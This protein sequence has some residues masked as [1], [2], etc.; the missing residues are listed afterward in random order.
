MNFHSIRFK[1]T[2]P[3]IIGL[4]LIIFFMQFYLLPNYV[5]DSKQQFITDTHKLIEASINGIALNLLER[6]LSPIY[7]NLEHLEEYYNGNWRNLLL[8]DPNKQRIYPVFMESQDVNLDFIHLVHPIIIEG[9]NL[10]K[11][12]VDVNWGQKKSQIINNFKQ[13]RMLIII[14]LVLIV[15]IS[16]VNEYH[17]IFLPLNNLLSATKDI[18]K[19]N[20]DIKLPKASKDEMGTLIK[21]FS[22]MLVELDFKNTALEHHAIVCEFDQNRKIINMNDSFKKISGYPKK[23]LDTMVIDDLIHVDHHA[24][25]KEKIVPALIKGEIWRGVIKCTNAQGLNYW[26]SSTIVPFATETHARKRFICIQTDITNQKKSEKKLLHLANHDTLTGLPTRILLMEHLSQAIE[27]AKRDKQCVAVA[28]VDL[29][30]FKAVNDIHGHDI[31][32]QLL[33]SVTKKLK[34]LLRGSDIIARIGGD[35]FI[36][37]LTE[38]KE[39]KKILTVASKVIKELSVPFLIGGKSLAIGASVGISVYPDDAREA[40]ILIKYADDAMYTVKKNGKRNYAFYDYDIHQENEI[41]R[42]VEIGLKK[43]IANDEFYLLYQPQINITENRIEGVESLIRWHNPELNNPTPNQFIVIAESIG[44]MSEIGEWILK[45]AITDLQKLDRENSNKNYK[46]S[47]NLS[48]RELHDNDSILRKLDYI[49][50]NMSSPQNITFEI[51][52]TSLISNITKA[53]DSLQLLYDAGYNIALDDF[54]TGYSSLK[55][56]TELPISIIK[57]DR[58]FV[59][60]MEQTQTD[61]EIIKAIMKMAESLN[62]QVICEGVEEESQLKLLKEF[63]CQIIQGYYFAPPMHIEDLLKYIKKFNHQS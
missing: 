22:S 49:D 32:D 53:R 15:L 40:E 1:L 2:L 41:L 11:F 48:G 25:L 4:L 34:Y 21:S 24:I 5:K 26:L 56:L 63:G 36:I 43:A 50:E 37:V 9:S 3:L 35:E 60:K 44:L 10:G 61:L 38:I 39:R 30:G 51:T 31:G 16:V 20:F 23:K 17:W 28:F 62:I 47:I 54:G 42:N 55:Y 57:I 14:I 13:F 58:S 59:V 27:R 29:D 7:S 45:Q 46:M 52:E 33:I 6:D 12:E 18:I 19:G 8:R